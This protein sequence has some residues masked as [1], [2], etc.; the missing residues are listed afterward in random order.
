MTSWSAAPPRGAA[1]R[2][3]ALWLRRLGSEKRVYAFDTFEGLPPPTIQDPD[4]AEAVAW[5]GQCR[6]DLEE[7]KGLF[8]RL[9]V[10]DRAVFVK[11]RFQETLPGSEVSRIALLHLDGDW[12][13]S[14]MTCLEN[15]WDRVSPGGIIQIDDYGYWEGCQKAVDEFFQARGISVKLRPIDESGRSLIKPAN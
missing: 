3:W 7:V 2:C 9:G 5:T 6:G 13:E 4:Y 15:L 1:P 10:L 8:R 11:G 14:T 12:Y